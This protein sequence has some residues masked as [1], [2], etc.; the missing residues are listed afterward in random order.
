MAE[1][2][3]WMYLLAYNLIRMIMAQ[4]AIKHMRRLC[5]CVRFKRTSLGMTIE[6][7][8]SLCRV[9]KQTFSNVESGFKTVK[10]ETIFKVLDCLGIVLWF[11]RNSIESTT[12]ETDEWL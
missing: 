2:E 6:T 9:S 12:G 5:K 7:A 1:K 10:A 4:A 11:D 8:A 3:I